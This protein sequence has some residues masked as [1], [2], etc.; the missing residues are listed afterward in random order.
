MT[1]RLLLKLQLGNKMEDENCTTIFA[2][3]VGAI[4][5]LGVLSMALVGLWMGKY[6][7]GFAW[8]GSLLQF[9]YHPLC[10]VIGLVFLY[11]EGEFLLSANIL[12][13][14]AC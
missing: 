8:D 13:W 7:G 2:V 12:T 9:N 1:A 3:C 14:F 4:Q 10:M 5:V 11:S 6:R